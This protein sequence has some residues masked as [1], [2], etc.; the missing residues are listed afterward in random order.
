MQMACLRLGY[1]SSACELVQ[2]TVVVGGRPVPDGDVSGDSASDCRLGQ[3]PD[4]QRQKDGRVDHV[5]C[6]HFQIHEWIRWLGD[7][8]HWRIMH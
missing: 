1:L 7:M 6:A 8:L 4:N 5:A 2:R 3:P